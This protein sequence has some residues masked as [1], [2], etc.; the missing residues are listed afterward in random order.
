[1]RRWTFERV[2]FQAADAPP[3]ADPAS[4]AST[5]IPGYTPA[6]GSEINQK[7]TRTMKANTLIRLSHAF[8]GKLLG[9]LGCALFGA[10]CAG[11]P[12][13]RVVLP[14]SPAVPPAVSQINS[15]LTSAALQTPAASTD[16]RLG[17]EDLLEVTIFNIPDG[18][19]TSQ[20]GAGP[21]PRRID[22]RVGQE[23]MITLPVLGDI[24]VAGLTTSAL[25]QVLRQ[26][27]NE[28]LYNPQ[29]GVYVKEYR[30]QRI[31][32][33]GAVRNPGVF[34]LTGPKTLGDLLALAGGVTDKASSRLHIYRQG[35]QD[36]HTYVVDLL[37]LA[38]NPGLVN[39]PAQPGDIID[40]PESGMFFVHGAVGR[41]GSYPLTQSYTLSQAIAV[42]GGVDANLADHSNVAIFRRRASQEADR[43][44]VD[45]KAI[46]DGQAADLPIEAD[47][48]IVVPISSAKW[49]LERFIG[50]IGLPRIP[51]L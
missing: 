22:V 45:L 51:L 47:D 36:R 16:Y 39:M 8:G 17:A 40:V 10:G 33:L 28:Y 14:E 50:T 25:E 38:S 27:Y 43:I 30:S 24:P 12:Q 11:A 46:L 26:R 1:M 21:I 37:A 29:V 35:G 48:V 9:L 32:V 23:G 4:A 44:A 15:A 19:Q 31:S 34:Q 20:G 13:A 5:A 7:E 49:F 41:P 18:S 42:V 6:V 2:A 3:A